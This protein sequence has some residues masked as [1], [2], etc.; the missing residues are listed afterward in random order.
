MNE[1][2]TEAVTRVLNNL[3]SL[4][5]SVLEL[6]YDKVLFELLDRDMEEGGDND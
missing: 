5:Y 1:S 2:L 3:Q 4:P 6:L